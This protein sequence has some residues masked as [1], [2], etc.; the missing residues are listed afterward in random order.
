MSGTVH[1]YGREYGSVP[2]AVEAL[3]AAPGPCPSCGHLRHDGLLAPCGAYAEGSPG[4]GCFAEV[5]TVLQ[6][7]YRKVHL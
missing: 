2:E 6:T 4:C 1:A 3:R 5:R 7:V